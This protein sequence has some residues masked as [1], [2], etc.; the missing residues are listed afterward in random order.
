MPPKKE[1]VNNNN[2]NTHAKISFSHKKLKTSSNFPK[3][4]IKLVSV[5]IFS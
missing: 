5:C 3:C 4:P 2:N 1:I